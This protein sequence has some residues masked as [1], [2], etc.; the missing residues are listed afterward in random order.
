VAELCYHKAHYAASRIAQLPGY[1]LPIQGTFFREFVVRCPTSPR[2]INRRLLEHNILGGLDISETFPNG[3]LLCVTEMNSRE[4][5]DAL[6]AAL[7]EF[8]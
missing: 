6:V 1:S 7:A 3:M 5:I 2:V 8:S 4:D